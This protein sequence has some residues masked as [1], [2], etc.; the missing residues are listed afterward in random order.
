[1]FNRALILGALPRRVGEFIR[2]M[3]PP[4]DVHEWHRDI[5]LASKQHEISLP[6]RGYIPLT[7]TWLTYL[8]IHRIVNFAVRK[9]YRQI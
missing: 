8:H 9:Y 4:A 3:I 1:M 7:A 2:A 6:L 5:R